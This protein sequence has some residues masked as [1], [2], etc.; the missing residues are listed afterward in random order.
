MEANNEQASPRELLVLAEQLRSAAPG[1][2]L[3]C[4]FLLLERLANRFIVCAIARGW[5]SLLRAT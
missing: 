4:C 1:S 3:R 2:G 5:A